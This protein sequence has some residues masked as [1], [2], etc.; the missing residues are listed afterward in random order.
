MLTLPCVLVST[1]GHP[2]R[3]VLSSCEE[4]GLRE[5]R[6]RVQGHPAE[7]ERRF[8]SHTGPGFSFGPPTSSEAM[9]QRL[10][11]HFECMASLR[12]FSG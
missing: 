6:P 12:H 10:T 4:A 9:T 7:L 8:R 1:F 11:I 3:S 2:Q 5:G